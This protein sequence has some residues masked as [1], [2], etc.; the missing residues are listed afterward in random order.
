MLLDA[1]LVVAMLDR[2]I[3]VGGC[4]EGDNFSATLK[5]CNCSM[6]Q[7]VKDNTA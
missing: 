1:W 7:L 4:L 5:I 2:F 3:D 6:S